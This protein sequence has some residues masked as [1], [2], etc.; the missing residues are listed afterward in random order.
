MNVGKCFLLDSYLVIIQNSLGPIVHLDIS[1]DSGHALVSA[2]QLLLR[3]E[4]WDKWYAVSVD[5]CR[6]RQQRRW[7]DGALL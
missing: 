7:M 3:T 1:M 6:V 5:L 4:S 2:C